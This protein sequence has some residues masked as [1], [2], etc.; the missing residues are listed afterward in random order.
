M[1]LDRRIRFIVDYV[2]AFQVVRFPYFLTIKK[3]LFSH[4]RLRSLNDIPRAADII[5]I[6]ILGAFVTRLLMYE[7]NV[8]G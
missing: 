4:F 8:L 7:M 3:G 6:N 5:F 1:Y 2:F